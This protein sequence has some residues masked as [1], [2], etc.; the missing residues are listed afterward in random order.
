MRFVA[1]DLLQERLARLELIVE[2]QSTDIGFAFVRNEDPATNDQIVADLTE[3]S[4]V[5]NA[6]GLGKDRPGSPVTDNVSFPKNG[7][8]WELNY[9]GERAF[10][11]QALAQ[12]RQR[13]LRVEDGW[14]YFLHGWTQVLAQILEIEMSADLFERLA[15]MAEPVRIAMG[16]ICQ[17][18]S[19]STTSGG[20]TSKSH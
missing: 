2:S 20:R 9:R 1:V 8:V 13:N 5:I 14:L 15:S 19:Q 12:R 16:G 17:S 4:L 3:G 18:P 10:L 7:A 11:R 6:T